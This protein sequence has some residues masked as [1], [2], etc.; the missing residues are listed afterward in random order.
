L[1]VALTSARAARFSPI[2]VDAAI[3]AAVTMA[4][5]LFHAFRAFPTLANGGGDNDALLRLVQVRD[6]LG[7][8][9]WYDL[10]QYRMGLEGG[11]VMHWSRLVDLPLAVLV[12]IL[13]EQATLVVWPMLLFALCLFL[14]VRTA[15]LIGGEIAVLPATVIGALA[16]FFVNQFRPG[17]L[18]HHNLQL[19]LAL[20]AVYSLAVA[21]PGEPGAARWGALAGVCSALMLAI[22]MEAAPYA[23]AACAVAAFR[24]LQGGD[25]ER[26][27]AQGFGLAFA[28]SAAIALWLAVPARSWLVLQCDAL[29]LPQATLAVIGGGGLALVASMPV[30]ARS[31]RTRLASFAALGTVI[32]CIA[33]LAFPACL[34]DPY[35]DL[36]PLLR[37]Y[38][39]SAV[40][41]A[42]SIITLLQ[43]DLVTFAGFHVTPLIALAVLGWWAATNK[44][45][46][47][48]AVVGAFLL[49]AVLVSFW[50]VRGSMFSLPLATLV[51][52]VWVARTR[53]RA[54]E[55]A[56][57]R[58]QLAMLASWL[59]SFNILW[60]AG[61]VF[62]VPAALSAS[63]ASSDGEAT[64]ASDNCYDLAAFDALSRV[65]PGTV[66]AISNL[67]SSILRQTPHRVLNGPYHRNNAGNRAALDIFM[68]DPASAQAATAALKIDYVAVCRGNPE[69]KAIAKWAPA[70]FL[71]SLLSQ[72]R[73]E[74]LSP[75]PDQPEAAGL[76]VLRVTGR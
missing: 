73:P 29:S 34:A 1:T 14:V 54:L 7:G 48:L 8:Q 67:G 70:G 44:L 52:A 12:S 71:S 25:G 40:S 61:A 46:R 3:A 19:A 38:W 21:K 75:L 45:A 58:A 68:G 72:S 43:T 10:T 32:A 5:V 66:L 37:S 15:R 35:A 20:A 27:L 33:V 26:R 39:L 63:A 36:D 53:T 11:F 9:G 13:G 62:L 50:Q 74:W 6:L 28:G 17:A 16:L 4:F 31:Q 41:E 64:I 49:V 76:E 22:G 51:L 60:Y 2:L 57:A 56:S 47:E 59:M 18:D 65:E 42:Q 55:D 69:T 24:F 30:L 23:G